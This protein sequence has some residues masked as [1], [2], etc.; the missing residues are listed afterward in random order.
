MIATERHEARRI[1]RQLLVRSGRQGD[2]GTNE[3]ITSL[4]DDILRAHGSEFWREGA[5]RELPARREPT[6][7]LRR[8]IV[9]QA[10]R[11]AERLHSKARRQLVK[12]DERI[13]TMLAFSGEGE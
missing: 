4:E 7:L 10:Q 6:S 13:A 12:M 2:P 11:R 1:D 5:G 3:I 9:R 8:L